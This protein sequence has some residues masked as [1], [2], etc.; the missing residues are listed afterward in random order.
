MAIVGLFALA[1]LVTW[2]NAAISA[3]ILVDQIPGGDAGLATTP[4]LDSAYRTMNWS[5]LAFAGVVVAGAALPFIINVRRR[6]KAS[7]Q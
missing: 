6:R 2:L 4:S 7:P 3:S 5:F 1:L